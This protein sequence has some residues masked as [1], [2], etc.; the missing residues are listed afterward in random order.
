MGEGAT[1]GDWAPGPGLEGLVRA[2][3]DPTRRAILLSFYEEPGAARTVDEVAASAGVHRTV[4]F[5]HLELLAGLGYLTTDR[6]RGRPGKPA[7]LFRLAGT[8]LSFHHPQ[9]RFLE[10]GQLLAATLASLGSEGQSAASQAGF[11]EG[12]RL[13]A[14]AGDLVDAVARLEQVG[15]EFSLLGDRATAR[16]CVFREACA[17]ARPVVC[18]IQAAMLAG[19]AAAAGRSVSVEPLGPT[20]DGRGCDYLLRATSARRERR[21]GRPSGT[22]SGDA[23]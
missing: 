20:P 9:R 2:L 6:R 3:Q 16:N 15:A 22:V 17:T 13:A 14:G 5:G 8:P 10:L 23:R 7:K 18:G 1:S 12:L 19:A 11:A 4:A 21:R